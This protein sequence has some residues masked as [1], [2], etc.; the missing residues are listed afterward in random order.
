MEG[1]FPGEPV[2]VRRAFRG[3]F[4]RWAMALAGIL[5]LAGFVRPQRIELKT[6]AWRLLDEDISLW[7]KKGDEAVRKGD[8]KGAAV[9]YLTYLMRNAKNARVIYNLACCYARMGQAEPAAQL[10]KRAVAAGF[11]DLN[12]IRKDADFE[13][14]RNTPAFQEAENAVNTMMADTGLNL[15][16]EASQVMHCRI[17]FPAGYSA[18]KAYPLVI[19]LHGNGGNAEDFIRVLSSARFPDM[20]CAAPEGAYPRGDLGFLPGHR[21][22]W[23]L[24]GLDK[25]LWSKVDP[26]TETYILTVIEACRSQCKTS[27]VYLAG[28]SQGVSAAFM[29]GIH[30]PG[31][32]NGI[33]GFSGIFPEESVTEAQ[34]QAA[35]GLP[36]FLAHGTRDPALTADAS[37][38]TRDTLKRAGYDVA[39]HEFDGGHEMTP[40][41]LEKAA[42]WIRKH[43]AR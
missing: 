2:T 38:K 41:L 20:V 30:N 22:S 32:I 12:L 42:E 29:T 18:D 24:E 11:T 10:L 36:V 31:K 40:E 5:I 39:Y 21:S 34:I 7:V 4:A 28:F 35:K 26:P 23:F 33:L 14:V 13:K 9:C 25:S 6:D 37:R 19:G 1:K 43:P 16:V 27:G 3:R 15:F 17:R 8:Y